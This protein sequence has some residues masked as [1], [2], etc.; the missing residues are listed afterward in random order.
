MHREQ[1]RCTCTLIFKYSGGSKALPFKFIDYPGGNKAEPN[2]LKLFQEQQ[3]SRSKSFKVFWISEAAITRLFIFES[4]SFTKTPCKSKFNKIELKK[5][6]SKYRT[7]IVKQNWM[8]ESFNPVSFNLP[9][10]SFAR[11][12]LRDFLEKTH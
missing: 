5:L 2:S 1:G 11:N 9:R 12:H 4:S 8:V 10:D 7:W 3:G 6:F